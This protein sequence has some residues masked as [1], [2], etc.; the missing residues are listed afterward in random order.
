MKESKPP[1]HYPGDKSFKCKAIREELRSDFAA[2]RKLAPEPLLINTKYDPKLYGPC[3]DGKTVPSHW[4]RLKTCEAASKFV[5][6]NKKL[7]RS[8]DDG[9]NPAIPV[10]ISPSQR[11]AMLQTLPEFVV[12]LRQEGVLYVVGQ[13]REGKVKRLCDLYVMA[14][15]QD[16]EFPESKFTEF[17]ECLQQL[18][19]MFP[20]HVAKNLSAY[21]AGTSKAETSEFQQDLS[22]N[23]P[24]LLREFSM[25]PLLGDS[26]KGES[27]GL[28][29]PTY[30][31]PPH[32]PRVRK[33]TQDRDLSPLITMESPGSLKD[34]YTY[35]MPETPL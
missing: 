15:T 22:A 4:Y 33:S 28:A 23:Q 16:G 31:P 30:Q 14:R 17:I 27:S 8:V 7:L 13:E 20:A 3:K 26:S 25:E 12:Q 29:G 6:A 19:E 5:S 18:Q 35:L 2:I 32:G 9:P 24:G 34:S 1:H 21:S 10:S 11:H